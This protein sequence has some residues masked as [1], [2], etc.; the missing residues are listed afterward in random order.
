[1]F[2]NAHIKQLMNKREIGILQAKK[3]TQLNKHRTKKKKKIANCA[4]CLILKFKTNCATKLINDIL[5]QINFNI[6]K[7]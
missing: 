5:T 7:D 2:L 1:M 6:I 3:L 4:C